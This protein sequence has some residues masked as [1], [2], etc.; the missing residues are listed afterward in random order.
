MCQ[1]SQ[2]SS[3]HWSIGMQGNT[4]AI[5]LSNNCIYI[6]TISSETYTCFLSLKNWAD[7]ELKKKT[8]NRDW[9]TSSHAANHTEIRPHS[10]IMPLIVCKF[11]NQG[12]DSGFHM[13]MWCVCLLHFSDLL[14]VEEKKPTLGNRRK[15][16]LLV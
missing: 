15:T 12:K 13:K 7:N 8:S 1:Y 4:R 14:W 16:D 9:S 11:L 6:L 5:H 2:A 10:D 3:L